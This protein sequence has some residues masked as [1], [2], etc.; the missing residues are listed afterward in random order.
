[1]RTPAQDKTVSSS[2]VKALDLITSLVA[3]PKGLSYLQLSE[4]GKMPRTT[5]R[6]IVQTLVGYGL[7]VHEKGVV[8][9]TEHFHSWAAPDWN[10]L[11]KRRYRPVLERIAEEVNEL[12]LVGAMSGDSVEHID[13]IEA[14][15][16]VQV[17][18]ALTWR[19]DAKQTAMG[20]LCIS[21]R[22]ELMA[23]I[24]DSDLRSELERIKRTGVSW[25]RGV[26]DPGAVSV[27]LPGLSNKP[28]EPV[29]AVAWPIQR[30]TEEAAEKAIAAIQRA[31]AAE[32]ENP[33]IM[34]SGSNQ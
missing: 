11:M 32:L 22:R 2:L 8:R 9:L 3:H 17:A 30:F 7:V 34:G 18:P 10:S 28:T 13:F 16:L 15:H 5:V 29:I 21:R 24:T 1:M 4:Q 19:L 25:N 23:A 31:V 33:T 12:V 27:A 14:D 6:R 20:K 26:S